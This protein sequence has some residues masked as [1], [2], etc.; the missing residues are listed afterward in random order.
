MFQVERRNLI[1]K[2]LEK[3]GRIKVDELAQKFDVTPVTIRRDLQY[4]ENKNVV[5]RTFGGAV[6]KSNLN[7]E[8]SYKEKSVNYKSQKKRIADYAVSLVKDGDIVLIDSGTTNMEIAKRLKEKQDLTIVTSDVLIV[9]YLINSTKFKILCTGGYVQNDVGA[10][11]GSR[12]SE[13]LRNIN[14]DIGFMGA[15][16]I[17]V[18]K[19]VS[20]PTFEKADVKKQMIKSSKKI[21]LVA[22]SSKFG[23]TSFAKICS[24]DEFDIIITDCDIDRKILKKLKKVQRNIKLV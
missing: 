7:T 4:L 12:A 13:F 24:V 11:I 1:I 18:K 2:E 9:G 22:D 23:Q 14:V 19:G 10:C 16:S 20:T 5:T 21:V 15:S 17:D 3:Q 8:I 6:L